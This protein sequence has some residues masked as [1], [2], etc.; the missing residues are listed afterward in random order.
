MQ[1]HEIHYPWPY[2]YW[3]CSDL[4]LQ[5]HL[6]AIN[7]AISKP[8]GIQQF[9]FESKDILE[10]F[11]FILSLH[12]FVLES[13][14]SLFIPQAL[15]F[16]WW[17][18]SLTPLYELAFGGGLKWWRPNWRDL[19]S[20][21]PY[22][23]LQKFFKYVLMLITLIEIL[24]SHPIICR[25]YLHYFPWE[26]VLYMLMDYDSLYANILCNFYMLVY[27]DCWGQVASINISVMSSA[28]MFGRSRL[29]AFSC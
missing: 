11:H 17:K 8:W 28:E 4:T 7:W 18:R 27:L 3:K 1:C 20:Q 25:K 29:L 10:K 9:N 16:L 22:V 24:F 14:N 19:V 2:I 5:F 13:L 15:P 21:F 6:K 23:Q 12:P 26:Y